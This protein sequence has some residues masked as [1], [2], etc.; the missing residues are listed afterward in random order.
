MRAPLL[1]MHLLLPLLQ[2]RAAEESGAKRVLPA[3]RGVR[4]A[5]TDL[6]AAA[7]SA[8]GASS[9]AV[10]LLKSR[11]ELQYLEFSMEACG[12]TMGEARGL[13]RVDSSSGALS[14][15][16]VRSRLSSRAA[17]FAG[18]VLRGVGW[19]WERG[20][21]P[22]LLLPLALTHQA[23]P[24]GHHP[25]PTGFLLPQACWLPHQ[26]HHTASRPL[27]PRQACL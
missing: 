12:L 6:A 14:Q 17:N 4:V 21:G 5:P 1:N 23:L 20:G 25:Q 3:S 13:G 22:L 16:P 11:P 2:A 26:G 7:V 10:R 24:A 27:L 9:A 19:G 18:R 15:L 8:T